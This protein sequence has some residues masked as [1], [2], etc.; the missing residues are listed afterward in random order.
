[1]LGLALLAAEASAQSAEA[2]REAALSARI[3]EIRA[4]LDTATDP[5]VI[6]R[7]RARIAQLEGLIAVLWVLPGA[8]GDAAFDYVPPVAGSG[9]LPF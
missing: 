3:A 7:G 6:A 9:A 8:R 5:D 4:G 2:R 1:M